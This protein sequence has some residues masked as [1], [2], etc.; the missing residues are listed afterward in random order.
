MAVV[1]HVKKSYF[2]IE[3]LHSRDGDAPTA[4][5]EAKIGRLYLKY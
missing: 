2:Q 5:A 4:V 1:E 3:E